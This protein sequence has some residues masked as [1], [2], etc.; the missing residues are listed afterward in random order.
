MRL[1]QLLSNATLANC[2]VAFNTAG[3]QAGGLFNFSN[4]GSTAG[5][6]TR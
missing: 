5:N 1:K 6:T 2:T 3:V 4:S